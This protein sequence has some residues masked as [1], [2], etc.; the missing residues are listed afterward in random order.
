MS[1]RNL[2]GFNS[3]FHYSKTILD[4]LDAYQPLTMNK[5]RIFHQAYDI[6]LLINTRMTA[7]GNWLTKDS[8]IVP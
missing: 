2:P 6:I 3:Y 1:F 4:K 8:Q 5:Q 7:L